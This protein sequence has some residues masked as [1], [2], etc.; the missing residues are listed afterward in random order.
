M[1]CLVTTVQH[2]LGQMGPGVVQGSF[3][4]P[5]GTWTEELRIN[6]KWTTCTPAQNK[7]VFHYDHQLVKQFN[8]CNARGALSQE[9]H[10]N[11]WNNIT[12]VVFVACL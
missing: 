11:C 3:L 5:C 7:M 10:V 9:K 8:Y 2:P 4:Q 6:N 1:N 12:A